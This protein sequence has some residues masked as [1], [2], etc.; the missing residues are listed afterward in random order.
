MARAR[1]VTEVDKQIR[2]KQ[3][4]SIAS[5]ISMMLWQMRYRT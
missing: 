1:K 5:K 3:E 4:N 2:K